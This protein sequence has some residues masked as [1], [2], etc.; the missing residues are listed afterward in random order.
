MAEVT[1]KSYDATLMSFVV[2]KWQNWQFDILISDLNQPNKPNRLD[3]SPSIVCLERNYPCHL[4][5][6]HPH[7]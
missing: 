6:I 1:C 7:E 5:I 2:E 4:A 3:T